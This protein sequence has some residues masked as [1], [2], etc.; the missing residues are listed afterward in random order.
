MPK[1]QSYY[2]VPP[3]GQ[4]PIVVKTAINLDG[5]QI[6][7][8]TSYALA[9]LYEHS[10]QAPYHDPYAGYAGPDYNFATG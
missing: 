8:A 1:P 7:T 2:Y 6:A 4:A 9:R 3:P 5:C 10:T